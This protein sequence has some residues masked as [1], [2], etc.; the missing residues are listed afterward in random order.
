MLKRIL[1]VLFLFLVLPIEPLFAY[2]TPHLDLPRQPE[3]ECVI[4]YWHNTGTSTGSEILLYADKATTYHDALKLTFQSGN[5]LVPN[6]A[7]YSS[8]ANDLYTHDGADWGIY[9]SAGSYFYTYIDPSTALSGNVLSTC[10][11]VFDPLGSSTNFSGNYNSLGTVTPNQLLLSANWNVGGDFSGDPISGTNGAV[12][13]ITFFTVSP[14]EYHDEPYISVSGN[15]ANICHINSV[16]T[17]EHYLVCESG[18]RLYVPSTNTSE[19]LASETSFLISNTT[20]IC[21]G[22]LSS[23]MDIKFDDDSLACI[24]P[25]TVI[26]TLL[27]NSSIPEWV[28]PGDDWGILNPLKNVIDFFINTVFIGT[29]NKA[30]SVVR[31]VVDFFIPDFYLAQN[32]MIAN[33]HNFVLKTNV[34][35]VSRFFQDISETFNYGYTQASPDMSVTVNYHGMSNIKI[36]NLNTFKTAFA[37]STMQSLI[38]FYLIYLIVIGIYNFIVGALGSSHSKKNAPQLTPQTNA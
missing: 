15:N 7:V 10:D 29:V 8:G 5:K 2:G 9:T 1:W 26:D 21:S 33:Y 11:L 14:D 23:S 18:S 12:F 13:T 19:V 24:K 17:D 25:S 38:A 30:Y 35:Q 28:I 20:S 32:F 16:D 36:L 37:N 6:L 31:T 27:P 22:I 34:N 3:N 4:H